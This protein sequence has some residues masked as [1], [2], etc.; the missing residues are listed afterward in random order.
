MG[1]YQLGG[2]SGVEWVPT[3]LER[4]P[5]DTAWTTVPMSGEAPP[6]MSFQQAETLQPALA[7]DAIGNRML[8]V[9]VTFVM[10]M[11]GQMA[12]YWVYEANLATSQWTKLRMLDRSITSGFFATDDAHRSGFL[13]VSPFS[14]VSL[15]PGTELDPL[16][17]VTQG[18]LPPAFPVAATLLGDGR[19]LVSSSSGELLRFDP[20]TGQYT[21]LGSNSAAMPSGYALAFDA[22]N[23]RAL[24]FGGSA[25]ASSVPVVSIAL[26]GSAMTPL[27][28]AGRLQRAA[29]I[30]PSPCK[31][32]RSS[33][34][35]APTRRARRSAMSGRST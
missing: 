24:A 34:Q 9:S 16:P 33:W 26:D 14:L 18:E 8:D 25:T 31:G 10:G 3:V 12:Q 5:Q 19:A 4:A 7:Y 13:S 1:S 29:R 28:I 21:S 23:N 27:T 17:F 30:P 32:T 2:D 35:A 20:A 11:F 6:S 15:A 22:V